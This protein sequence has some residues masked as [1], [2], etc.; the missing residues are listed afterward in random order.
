MTQKTL[1]NNNLILNLN[2]FYQLMKPRVMSLVIFTCVVGLLISPS[3]INFFTA[4]ISLLAVAIGAGASGA[5]N[6]WYE[7]DL[8]AI[9]QRTCLRPIPTGKISRN[10]AFFFGIFASFF[11]VLVLY[12]FSNL[13]SAIIL[14]FT[15]FFYVVIYTILLTRRIAQN[16]VI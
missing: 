8:D 16:I 10:H 14:A 4:I 13:L 6:M 3:D 12:F 11:S 15:V 1:I 2:S 7:S 5:L 9:M